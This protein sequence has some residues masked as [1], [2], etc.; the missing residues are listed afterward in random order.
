MRNVIA[1]G[2]L[3][4][5]AA[6]CGTRAGAVCDNAK[7]LYGREVRDCQAK[8]AA[9]C[10]QLE[11]DAIDRRFVCENAVIRAAGL[12]N[13]PEA[14]GHYSLDSTVGKKLKLDIDQCEKDNPTS[15]LTQRCQDMLADLPKNF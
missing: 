11:L 8:V 10:N 15:G 7:I 9:D 6:G 3:L 4:L 1:V 5:L 13:L 14:I 2:A 12:S